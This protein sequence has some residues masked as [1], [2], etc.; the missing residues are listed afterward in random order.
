MAKGS[1]FETQDLSTFSLSCT[2]GTHKGHQLQLSCVQS[3]SSPYLNLE[4]RIN[5]QD[6]GT[7]S[8]NWKI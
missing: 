1:F 6:S 8:I 2:K 7:R 4:K 5:N 3:Q